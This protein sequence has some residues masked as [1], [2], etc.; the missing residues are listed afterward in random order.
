[1]DLC[2]SGSGDIGGSGVSGGSSE[3]G[4]SGGSRE[5]DVVVVN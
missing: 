2:V 3:S 4:H 5:V 1:M